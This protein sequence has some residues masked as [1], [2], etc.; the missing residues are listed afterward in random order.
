MYLPPLLFRAEKEVPSNL[1]S[2]RTPIYSTPQITPTST[3]LTSPGPTQTPHSTPWP[4]WKQIKGEKGMK[5][6]NGMNGHKGMKGEKGQKGM[7]GEKGEKG[8]KGEKGEKGMKGENGMNGQKGMK[9]EKGEEGMKGENGMNGQKG[10]KGEKGEKGMKGEK[11]EKGMKGE[12]G[13]NGQKGTKG[14]KGVNGRK[15]E[16]GEMGMKGMRGPVG[17]IG[18]AGPLGFPGPPGMKGLKGDPG[19]SIGGVTYVRWGRTVCPDTYSTELVYKGLAAGS[20]HSQSGGGSNYQCMTE[21]PQNY[22]YG[23][24]TAEA[25]F[26]H[27]AEYEMYGNVPSSSLP[28][29]NHTVP[30]VVCYVASR[31]ALLMIPGTYIC[32]T[33]WTREYFG[34]LMTERSDPSHNRATFE[35]MDAT[36]EVIA[37]GQSNQDGALFYHVEPHCGSLPCPPYEEEKEIACAVCTR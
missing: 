16:K 2:Q 7:K 37:G 24:G 17:P 19:A 25:S 5:G 28:L 33:N 9:G 10:I 8:M 3:K 30:C 15:G 14:K 20:N 23:P 11:G 21:N 4:G 34:Y 12:H 22:D 35:C 1:T 18:P 6:E 13:M 31:V 26:I 36:P 27:G 29:H 32:P